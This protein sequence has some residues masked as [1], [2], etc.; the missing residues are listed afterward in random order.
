MDLTQNY[1]V[2][3]SVPT[4]P[5]AQHLNTIDLAFSYLT[6][7]T[8]INL[9][10]EIKV[11]T[12][13]VRT[14]ELFGGVRLVLDNTV[15]P[16]PIVELVSAK[17]SVSLD[18][19]AV[20][21]NEISMKAEHVTEIF[22]S[23]EWPIQST[24]SLKAPPLMEMPTARDLCDLHSILQSMPLS[25]F[26]N[27]LT[28][29]QIWLN[30]PLVN[31]PVLDK[32]PKGSPAKLVYQQLLGIARTEAQEIGAVL[33][34]FQRE[35]EQRFLGPLQPA[36]ARTRGALR[37]RGK[38]P[39]S[40]KKRLVKGA[41]VDEELNV[42]EEISFQIVGEPEIRE[43]KLMLSLTAPPGLIGQTANILLS[44]QE[45]E[46]LLG[47][48]AIEAGEDGTARIELEVDLQSIGVSIKDGRLSADAFQVV[49]EGS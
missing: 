44:I 35:L 26:N 29:T 11:L 31:T 9:T 1:L 7:F 28:A 20:P 10:T 12:R 43:G 47:I 42:Q 18:Y 30:T 49:V 25:F 23:N 38:L 2:K 3:N 39:G 33:I 48:V 21:E 4:E 5:I 37:T 15:K 19:L 8:P 6:P 46:I 45:K 17:R 24:Y 16:L 41:I 32:T 27:E 36:F 14:D 22:E 34:Q 40:W 13:K